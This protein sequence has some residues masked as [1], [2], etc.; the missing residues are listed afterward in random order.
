MSVDL[1]EIKEELDGD[2][3]GDF[4]DIFFFKVICWIVYF[5]M[6]CVLFLKW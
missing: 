2:E 6:L 1:D 5:V 3:V 4:V